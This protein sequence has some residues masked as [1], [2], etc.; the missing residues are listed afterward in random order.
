MQPS[1]NGY[2]SDSQTAAASPYVLTRSGS[3]FF[4]EDGDLAHEFYTEVKTS[5]GTIMR[6]EPADRLQPQGEVDLPYP[7]FNVDFPVVLYEV[8]QR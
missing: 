7:R 3:M 1:A 4:D 6:K 2:C 5:Q 8:V